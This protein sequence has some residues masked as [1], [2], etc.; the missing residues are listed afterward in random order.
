MPAVRERADEGVEQLARAR[1]D[2]RPR[3]LDARGA[4]E[5]VDGGGAEIR[6]DLLVDRRPDPPLD[7]RAQL[8][9]RV[10]LAGRA[11][12]LVVG[13]RQHLLVDV[14]DLDVDRGLG[15][16]ARASSDTVRVSPARA[17]T[18][19]DSISPSSRPAP[20]SI[21]VSGWPSPFAPPRSTTRVSPSRASRSSAGTSSATELRSASTSCW[22]SSSGTT[23]SARGTSRLVQSTISGRRLHLDRRAEASTAR[24]PRSAARS[25]TRASRRDGAASARRRSRTSRRCATRPPRP[26]GDP[27]R[28]SRRAPAAEPS[29]CGTPGSGPSRRDRRPRARPRARARAARRRP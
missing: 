4:Y 13:L 12:E 6:V 26:R 7:V 28:R 19:A 23:D 22:T 25:R 11:R 18:S 20:S 17:P 15:A 24:S 3:G 29:P 14:L 1:L 21:T 5:L 8:G 2:E 10:E 16:V 27:C 9:E